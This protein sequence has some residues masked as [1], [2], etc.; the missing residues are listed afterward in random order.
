[1]LRQQRRE[2]NRRHQGSPEGRLDHR[3][4]Q[5]AYRRRAR[6][7]Q[8]V[9]DA[10]RDTPSRSGSIPPLES[11]PPCMTLSVE[12]RPVEAE[13]DDTSTPSAHGTVRPCCRICGR[14]G[15]FVDPFRRGG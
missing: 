6:P 14:G 9:T 4:R 13:H 5:R 1:M 8:S 11:V 15:R 12:D 10:G 7:A 3:D 2:A